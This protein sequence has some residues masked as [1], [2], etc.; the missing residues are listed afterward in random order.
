MTQTLTLHIADTVV[1]VVKRSVLMCV[2]LIHKVFLCKML[3]DFMCY[4]TE[5]SC[6][7]Y[8]KS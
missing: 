3:T 1:V 8:V 5:V 2:S 7:K 6:F 4:K